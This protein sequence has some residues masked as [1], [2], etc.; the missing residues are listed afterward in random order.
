MLMG[1]RLPDLKAGQLL[2]G[3][4]ELSHLLTSSGELFG[5]LLMQPRLLNEAVLGILLAMKKLGLLLATSH[6]G[7]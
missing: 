5:Q 6:K 7:L 1:V 3:E 4:S 2:A